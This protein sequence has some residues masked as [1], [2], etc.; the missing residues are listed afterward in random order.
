[1]KRRLQVIQVARSSG[2]DRKTASHA[3][4]TDHKDRANS[5]FWRLGTR[6]SYVNDRVDV[7]NDTLYALNTSV[8]P[9]TCPYM[10]WNTSG[11]MDTPMGCA[12]RY[13]ANPDWADR[14]VIFLAPAAGQG[15][16][17]GDA[18]FIL[19]PGL[20]SSSDLVCINVPNTQFL[21]HEFGHYMGL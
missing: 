10:P 9:G 19:E 14:V 6:L 18:N 4:I 8:T 13:A 2:A 12:R 1:T 17:S 5:V 7:D 21:A 20:L 11:G 16:S 15:I 3:A